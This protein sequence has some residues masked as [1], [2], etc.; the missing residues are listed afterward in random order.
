MALD[1][2]PAVRVP[3][4]RLYLDPNNPRLGATRQP[5][6]EDTEKLF[7]ERTQRKLEAR[8]RKTYKALK[9]LV[10]SIV[11]MG[12][13]PVD[14]ILVWE[15]PQAPGHYIV[16]EGNARTTALR[17]IRE[18]HAREQARL[19]KARADKL[20]DPETQKEL[21]D[22]VERL[23]AVIDATSALEVLPV[24]APSAAELARTL[25]RLLGVRHIS[26]AQQWKPQATNVYI[27]SLY[28]QLFHETYGPEEKLRLEEALLR[29]TGGMVSLNSWKVR[30]SIQA[31]VAF[32]R[33]R[34]VYEDRLPKGERF[35]ETDQ[36]YFLYLFEPG[37]AREQFGLTDS[38]LW[39]SRESEEVLFAWAFGKP[40]AGRGG[41]PQRLPR[42]GGRAPLEHH[43]ALRRPPRDALLAPARRAPPRQGPSG[44]AD[45]PRLERAPRAALAGRDPA[46]SR[47]V[48]AL[49]GGRHARRRPRGDQA[50]DRR[51]VDPG[52]GV[53]RDAGRARRTRAAQAQAGLI[54]SPPGG[55]PRGAR[56]RRRS[57]P[58][59][60]P[61]APG[62]S[63]AAPGAGSR[64]A[65]PPRRP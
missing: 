63:R 61:A 41:E 39:L 1:L 30:K 3:F 19:H 64:R 25:P 11:N 23:A 37:F 6:Y 16:V 53:P 35:Q 59:R 7:D 5:G 13:M 8:M 36:N 9:D 27:Y 56:G 33:F 34:A 45:G 10:A 14:A 54:S 26:H 18:E 4:D 60:D 42:R 28:R 40:R 31:A 52:Q 29:E 49:H 47:G 32:A 48:A 46:G 22:R 50:R 20:L 58:R 51:D 24:A 57:R 21:G 55:S 15:V 44:R 2:K 17:T 62:E 12:W 38:D 43:R 65:R